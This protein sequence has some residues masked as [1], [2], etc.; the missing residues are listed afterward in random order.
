[1]THRLNNLHLADNII[2][3]NQGRIIESGNLDKLIKQRGEFS[4]LYN[5]QNLENS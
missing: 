3:L 2:F 5:S 1:M 4:V